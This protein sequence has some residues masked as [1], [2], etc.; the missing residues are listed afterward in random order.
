MSSYL[1]KDHISWLLVS[2]YNCLQQDLPERSII[3]LEFL[4]VF[5][6]NNFQCLKMLV[7]AYLMHGEAQKSAALI[8]E[9]QH[10][11][12]T[13]D[14][15]DDIRFLGSFVARGSAQIKISSAIQPVRNGTSPAIATAFG[16]VTK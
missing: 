11:S 4:R 14:E 9:I 15:R 8:Q 6:K 16:P 13:E 1:T 7:Y 3:L 10:L 12:L 5:D 2:A